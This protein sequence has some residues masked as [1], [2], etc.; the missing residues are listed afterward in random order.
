[1]S[2]ELRL[3]LEAVLAR[4]HAQ[5]ARPEEFEVAPAEI[6]ENRVYGNVREKIDAGLSGQPEAIRCK[7]LW[8][9]AARLYGV[10][11]PD[12]AWDGGGA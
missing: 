7:R 9:N 5:H 1:M 11:E 8:E 2:D 12:R 10:A 6:W 4:D 3:S